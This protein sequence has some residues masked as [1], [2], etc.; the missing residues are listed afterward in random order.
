M[1]ILSTGT[2]L[3]LLSCC[4]TEKNSTAEG[5]VSIALVVVTSPVIAEQHILR[6]AVS[7]TSAPVSGV[8]TAWIVLIK[9]NTSPP[10]VSQADMS[11]TSTVNARAGKHTPS[12]GTNSAFKPPLL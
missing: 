6:A 5:A 1:L 12:A 3:Q 10:S 7:T 4:Y 2:C 9:D 8:L 11:N